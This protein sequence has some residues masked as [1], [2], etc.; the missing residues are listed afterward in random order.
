MSLVGLSTQI[1]QSVDNPC[2]SVLRVL[3]KVHMSV[4][5]ST[6]QGHHFQW[7]SCALPW[8]EP[9]QGMSCPKTHLTLWW[10]FSHSVMSDSCDPWT[11]AHQSP[12]SMGLSR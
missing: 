5:P 8:E 7:E 12:L 2:D 3:P 6:A 1:T 9:L 10:W 4:R 11:V